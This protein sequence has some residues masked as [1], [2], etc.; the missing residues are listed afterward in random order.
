MELKILDADR[1]VIE[2]NR[3]ES[4]R[5]VPPD[6]VHDRPRRLL[7]LDALDTL[8]RVS[9]TGADSH[10]VFVTLTTLAT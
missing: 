7:A 10:S 6:V 5:R 4:E 2:G 8:C 3:G 1:E 9:L